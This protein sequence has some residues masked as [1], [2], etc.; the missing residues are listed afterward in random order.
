MPGK[1]RKVSSRPITTYF[2]A[3]GEIEGK[4]SVE[5]G[6]GHET[7]SAVTLQAIRQIILQEVGKIETEFKSFKEEIYNP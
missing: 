3:E 5:Q 7:D 6:A 2:D 1:G 4:G